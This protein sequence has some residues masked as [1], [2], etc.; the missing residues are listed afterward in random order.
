MKQ[1]PLFKSHYSLG[2]SILTLEKPEDVDPTG[3]DSIIQ[4]CQDY[5]IKNLQIKIIEKKLINI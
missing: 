1:I 5:K 3:P 2:K 4:I